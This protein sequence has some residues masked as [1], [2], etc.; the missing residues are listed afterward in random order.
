MSQLPAEMTSRKLQNM[1]TRFEYLPDKKIDTWRIMEQDPITGVYLGDCDDFAITTW[2]LLCGGKL[3][4]FWWGILTFK[5]KFHK[6]YTME[7]VSHLA[8]EYNGKFVDNGFRRWVDKKDMPY[9]FDGYK[10]NNI[11][12]VAAKLLLGELFG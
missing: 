7:G 10:I 4:T 12:M 6:C 9:K 11:L 2:Y 1:F 8:L 3:S 5:V